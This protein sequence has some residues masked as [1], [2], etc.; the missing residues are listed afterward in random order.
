MEILSITIVIGHGADILFFNTS[1][2]SA[3]FPYTGA[4][5]VKGEAAKGSGEEYIK[6]HFAGI[7][8]R[9]VDIIQLRNNGNSNND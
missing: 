5:S 1:L 4:F 8:Y 3:V 7:P 2:P 9:V 6:T